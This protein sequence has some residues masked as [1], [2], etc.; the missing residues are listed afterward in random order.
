MALVRWDPFRD[1]MSLQQRMNRLFEDSLF[2]TRT[3]DTSVFGGWYPT[4]DIVDGES[5]VLLR[6]EL[7][8]MKREE[9]DVSV[10]NSTL[11]INGEKKREDE[12]SEERYH[13]MERFFGSFTR[14]FTLPNSID[15]GGVKASY[16]DGVLE[17]VL[18][19]HEDAQP[20]RIT[21]GN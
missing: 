21:V 6:A 13:R 4:V 18:P 11:T 12:V 17:V 16:R 2:R 8:G 3:E 15:A 1:L 10:E 14:S 9:I 5:S 7:P 19:K 20:K